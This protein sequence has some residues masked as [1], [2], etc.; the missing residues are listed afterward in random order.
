M[1]KVRIKHILTIFILGIIA[2]SAYGQAPDRQYGEYKYSY[3]IDPNGYTV[4]RGAFPRIQ[5][6]VVTTNFGFVQSSAS[7][8]YMGVGGVWLNSPIY[9]W[10]GF[11]D[12]WYV[13]AYRIGPNYSYFLISGD[14]DTIRIQETYNNGIVDVYTHCDP[15]ERMNNAPTY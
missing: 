6:I 12:G 15:N 10:A 9:Q 5:P 3:S 1:K 7:Y 11:Q 8:M 14:F 13:Y 4:E 2:I